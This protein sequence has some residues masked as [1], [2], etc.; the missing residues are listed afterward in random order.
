M[1]YKR[2]KRYRLIHVARWSNVNKAHVSADDFHLHANV[3]FGPIHNGALRSAIASVAT[4]RR[5]NRTCT[6]SQS[7][8]DIA[9]MY[10]QCE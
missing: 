7:V 10:A 5:Y 3:L 9:N 8:S 2:N 1:G 4:W 6:L